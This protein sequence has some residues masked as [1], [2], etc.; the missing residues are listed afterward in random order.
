MHFI[1]LW[2]LFNQ[3]LSRKYYTADYLCNPNIK[4]KKGWL[5]LANTSGP[6]IFS[7]PDAGMQR[8]KQQF[9][10]VM[11]IPKIKYIYLINIYLSYIYISLSQKSLCW[12]SMIPQTARAA[13]EC[14][15]SRSLLWN[16]KILRNSSRKITSTNMILHY[17]GSLKFHWHMSQLK[18]NF[19]KNHNRFECNCG[20]INS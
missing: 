7:R 20:S 16:Y 19:E 2:Q 9:Q 18:S 12:Q 1:A 15:H 4:N 17:I 8:S 14:I 10:N 6:Y 5:R 13:Q 11:L 3:H